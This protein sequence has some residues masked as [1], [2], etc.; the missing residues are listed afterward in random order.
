LLYAQH[1]SNETELLRGVY[2][3]LQKQIEEMT[4]PAESGTS[5]K[6]TTG[7]EKPKDIHI[8]G[9]VQRKEIF[10]ISHDVEL[11]NQPWY[12]GKLLREQACVL[13]KNEG[14]FLLRV[15]LIILNS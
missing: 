14:D 2:E 6:L 8:D 10:R 7:Y 5:T 13:L 9:T 1:E 11:E 3:E 15:T 12:H 4:C